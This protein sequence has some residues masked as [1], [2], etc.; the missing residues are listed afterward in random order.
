MRAA[1]RREAEVGSGYATAQEPRDSV[2]AGGVVGEGVGR[3]GGIPAVERAG[4]VNHS[5]GRDVGLYGGDS[6]GDLGLG[7]ELQ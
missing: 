6:E 3:A 4:Q 5:I 2:G 7:I 1:S